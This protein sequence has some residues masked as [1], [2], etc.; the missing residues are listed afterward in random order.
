MRRLSCQS[1]GA[2]MFANQPFAFEA[3][4][5]VAHLGSGWQ[6]QKTDCSTQILAFSIADCFGLRLITDEDAG[7]V[8]ELVDR[9]ACSLKHATATVSVTLPREAHPEEAAKS[10]KDDLIEPY[11]SAIKPTIR[12][13]SDVERSQFFDAEAA[14]AVL[15]GHAGTHRRTHG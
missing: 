14:I 13:F 11:L 3:H 10:I 2:I 4:L 7:L 8:V 12:P 6:P 15:N 1:C 5:I 9:S